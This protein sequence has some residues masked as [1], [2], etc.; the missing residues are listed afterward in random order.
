[1]FDLKARHGFLRGGFH[2]RRD[3]VVSPDADG[4]EEAG[5]NQLTAGDV[6]RALRHQIVCDDAEMGAEIEDVPVFLAQD[7]QAGFRLKQRMA[8]ARDR[9][10]ERGFAA[11]VGA[12]DGNVLA[13]FDREAEAVQGE[14]RAALD[15]DVFEFE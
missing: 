8:F 3:V 9:F 12:E 5:E 2:F 13:G 6:A 4:A 1:M 7:A 11:A 10:D 15:A 14:T